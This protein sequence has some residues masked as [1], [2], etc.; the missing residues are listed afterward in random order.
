M[1]SLKLLPVL[2]L[3]CALMA[4]AA[5][6]DPGHGKARGK[7]KVKDKQT[8]TER[9]WDRDRDR[10]WNDDESGNMRFQ[11]M[12]RN[13][14]GRISRN[15]WRG[16][17]QS[18]ANHDWNGDG[19]LSGNEVRPA[20]QWDDDDWNGERGWEDRFE[21]LDRNDDRYLSQDE[22]PGAIRLFNILDL[23]RDGRVSFG[24]VREHYRNR[25]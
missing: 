10:H 25:Q 23:N 15:E 13:G 1:Q 2:A 5:T 22:W 21:T 24:E 3:A 7:N 14:D 18:F 17:D 11:G 16:N 20:G 6:A 4:P 12:D 8:Q 9:N 19:I